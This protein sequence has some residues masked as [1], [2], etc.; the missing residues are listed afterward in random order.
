MHTNALL[1]IQAFSGG[2]ANSNLLRGLPC[3]EELRSVDSRLFL[4]SQK[5]DACVIY[6]QCHQLSPENPTEQQDVLLYTKGS[7]CGCSFDLHDLED[8][9]QHTQPINVL[10]RH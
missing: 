8:R 7:G 6:I 2:C 4:G 5:Q 1:R 10:K 9:P 3:S